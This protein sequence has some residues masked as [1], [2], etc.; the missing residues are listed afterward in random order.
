MPKN[1]KQKQKLLYIMKFF[2]EKTDDDY[3]VTVADIIEYLDSY[4]IVAER[5]SIYNDIE[6]LRDF[7]MDIVKTKVGKISLFSLVSREFTLEEIKLLIDAVQSSKFITLKKSRDLIRK[8]ETLTSE[9]QAKELHRQVIVANRV[10]NSNEDIYR[11][12]DSINRAI[13]NK[14][15][16]SFYYTQWAVSR[17]GAKK[18]VRV[19]RHD[20]KR[21]LLTPKALTWDD[22]NY[23]LI[24][25]DKEAEKLKHF[26]VDKMED[27]A[28]EETR[29]DSTKAVDK[30]DLAVY[31]KQVFGMYGGETVSVKLRFDDSLIGVVVDR[32]SDRVFIQPHGDGT[33]TMS[34]EVMLSPQF[35]GWLFSFGDKVQITSPKSAK[36]EF[37]AYLDSVK[38]QY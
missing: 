37:N 22:E 21:Y 2:M 9:N 8:I 12:I 19:R 31:T 15:K 32:F 30:F 7:G 35:F 23:Y 28:V 25:Y 17:T 11:N 20:G 1:P 14:R 6:C 38:A 27:I 26:R 4:E 10:K 33:F 5:K 18:I 29:A 16:I 24:A 36:Q 34:A 3:G 13:N